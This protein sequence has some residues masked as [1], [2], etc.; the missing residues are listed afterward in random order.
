VHYGERAL[1]WLKII[2]K[3]STG[4]ASRFIENMAIEK[5]LKTINK[6]F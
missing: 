4:H 6:F 1:W 2:A 3:G 5:L